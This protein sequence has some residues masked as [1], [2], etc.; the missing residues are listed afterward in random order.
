MYFKFSSEIFQS[1]DIE[2]IFKTHLSIF[3][4]LCIN[5]IY[6]SPHVEISKYYRRLCKNKLGL[7]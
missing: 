4:L 1:R 7:A 3:V 5:S 2:T 6:P